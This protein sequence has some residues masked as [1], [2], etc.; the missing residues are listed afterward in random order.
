MHQPPLLA[1]I[2]DEQITIN[3]LFVQ[4]IVQPGD[5]LSTPGWR[6]EVLRPPPKERGNQF[7]QVGSNPPLHQTIPSEVVT[8]FCDMPKIMLMLKQYSLH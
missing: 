5:K 6:E 7:E 4:D 1:L 3:P 8:A 2:V